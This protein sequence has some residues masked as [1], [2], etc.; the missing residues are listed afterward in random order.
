MTGLEL[1]RRFGSEALALRVNGFLRPL[2]WVIDDDAT[3]ETFDLTSIEGQWVYKHS[4]SFLLIVAAQ[5]VLGLKLR[6]THSVSDALV[7]EALDGRP[8]SEEDVA[9]IEEEM[10]RLVAQEAPLMRQLLSL[11]KASRLLREQGKADTARLLEQT[12]EDPVELYLCDGVAG[13]FFGPLLP[14][15]GG[16][17]YFSLHPLGTGLALRMPRLDTGR[18]LAPF[19]PPTETNQVFLEYSRWLRTLGVATMSDVHDRIDAGGDKELVLLSEA[20]HEA[21]LAS[22]ASEILSRP[23]CRLLAIAGPSS[24][25]KTT[26]TH[27]LKVQLKIGGADALTLSLDDY[28]KNDEDRPLDEFGAP[29]YETIDALDTERLASDLASLVA[30]KPTAVPWFDFKTKRR[31]GERTIQLAQGS[32]LLVEGLHGLNDRVIGSVPEAQRFGLFVS[33]LTGVSLDG[34]NRTSTTDNRLLRRL[35]RDAR[36]R[37]YGPEETLA[38]WPSVVRGANKYIFPFQHNADRL[39]NSVHL[40]ELPVLKPFAE[41]LLRQVKR[42]SPVYGEACRLLEMLRHVPVMN[43]RLVPNNSVLREFIGGSIIDI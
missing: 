38:Q 1:A 41:P 17:A 19:N 22:I 42:S 35:V 7:W 27:K 43:E 4:L 11:D 16:L 33:P 32:L 18:D 26:S 5:R 31:G 25:G 29:D 24:A 20:L 28:Y 14:T 40:Y 8:L 6:V 9:T 30:G 39:F 37:G 23:A 12:G 2:D 34:H 10:R 3:V 13:F 15:F 21:R 36:T